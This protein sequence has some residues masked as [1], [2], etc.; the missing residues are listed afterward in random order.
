MDGTGKIMLS[1]PESEIKC[2]VFFSYMGSSFECLDLYVE[3]GVP[4]ED[5]NLEKGHW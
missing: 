4:T 1:N 5:R 3:L 2:H